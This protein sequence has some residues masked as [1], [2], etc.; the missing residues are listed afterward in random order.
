MPDGA[1][2]GIQNEGWWDA[3]A[4][5]GCHGWKWSFAV[6]VDRRGLRDQH[7]PFDH[8]TAPIRT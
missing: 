3:A 5:R 1:R 4:N 7:L 2:A 6:T 8:S